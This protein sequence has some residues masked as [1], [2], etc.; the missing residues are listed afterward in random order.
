MAE[1]RFDNRVVLITGAGGGMHS[2]FTV[3]YPGLFSNQT[4]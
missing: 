4:L 2:C 3:C 1:L